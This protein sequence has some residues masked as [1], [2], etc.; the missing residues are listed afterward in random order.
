[1]RSLKS[2]YIKN[3]LPT[4]LL[5]N[6]TKHQDAQILFYSYETTHQIITV[7]IR[8]IPT[9]PSKETEDILGV[10][11]KPVVLKP[12]SSDRRLSILKIFCT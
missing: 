2:M 6:V 4:L 8:Y 5:I 7:H 9:L 11:C 10:L 1:M 12:S 3:S